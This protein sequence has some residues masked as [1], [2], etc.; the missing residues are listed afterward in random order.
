MARIKY[1]EVIG[2]DVKRGRPPAGKKPNKEAVQRLYLKESRSIREI[3]ELIGCSKDMVYR[4]LRDHNIAR[5]PGTRRSRLY[6][7][8]I[9]QLEAGIKEKG[10]R[11][12]AR[13]LGVDPSTLRYHLKARRIGQ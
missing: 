4:T 8:D 5:R 1:K 3:A 11:G 6:Q 10:I 12:L 2:L 7:F 9:Q 13:T